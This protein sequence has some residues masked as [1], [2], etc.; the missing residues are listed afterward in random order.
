[1][2]QINVWLE[3]NSSYS[4]NIIHIFCVQMSGIQQSLTFP[5]KDAGLFSELRN[6]RLAD[7][8]MNGSQGQTEKA[9]AL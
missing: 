8:S 3:V 2:L 7:G 1:M 4:I 9:T 6:I 5:S